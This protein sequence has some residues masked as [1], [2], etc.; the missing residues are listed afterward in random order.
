MKE[1]IILFDL[2]DTL[3]SKNEYVKRLGDNLAKECGVSVEEVMTMEKDYFE[4]LKNSNDFHIKNLL[5]YLNK[6]F[7]KKIELE[8]FN[9]DK[10]KIYS[11]SLFPDTIPVLKKL[12]KNNFTL[13]IYSQGFDDCQRVKMNA[14]GIGDFIDNRFIFINRNK[15]DPEF[16]RTLP[17]STIIDDKKE[18][19]EQ[20][21]LVGRFNLTWINR[22]ND[23]VI[24]GKI[25][26]AK[27][28]NE[29]ADIVIARTA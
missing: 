27:D 16:I 22:K 13:G 8:K 23:E 10:L 28:L 11:G 19:I 7:D 21:E 20:L 29:F 9:S 4:S 18:K 14:S 1:K 2:D 3:F 25:T 6:N 24:G 17:N 5:K 26:T 15:S 12:Q